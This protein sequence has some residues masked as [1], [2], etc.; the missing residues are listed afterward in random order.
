MTFAG[1]TK[2]V[3]VFGY[4]VDTLPLAGDAECRHRVGGA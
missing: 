4:P 3:G 2:I 1:T